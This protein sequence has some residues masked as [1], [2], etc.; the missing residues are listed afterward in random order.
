[1]PENPEASRFLSERLSAV[2]FA[3]SHGW[4]LTPLHGKKA[5]LDNW[6]TLGRP[7]PDLMRQWARAGN[8]GVR[9]GAVSGIFVI[10]EDPRNGG[11][12]SSLDLPDTLMSETGGAPAEDGRL[13]RHFYFRYPDGV[14]LGNS[15]GKLRP[16]IDTKGEGGQ[17]VLPGSIHPETG[18]P[19]RWLNNLN[20]AELPAHLIA[21]LTARPRAVSTLKETAAYAQAALEAEI[22]AVLNAPAH[23][24]N[25]VL[26][27]AAFNLGQLVGGGQIEENAVVEALLAAAVPRRSESEARSTIRSGLEAGRREPRERAHGHL[28][29]QQD[30]AHH[31]RKSGH[32]RYLRADAGNAELFAR[33]HGAELRYDHRRGLWRV[34]AGHSWR[35]DD[36]GKAWRLAKLT[37]RELFDIAGKL[38][39]ADE[40]EAEAKWAL[41]SMNR[42]RLSSMLRLAQNEPPLS[43]A[44]NEWDKDPW[45]LGVRNGVV[46]LRSGQLRPGRRVDRITKSIDIVYQPDAEAPRWNRLVDEVLGHDQSLVAFVHRAA[47]YSATGSTREQCLFLCHGD[48]SNGKST[49]LRTMLN[50]LGPYGCNAPFSTLEMN[51]RTSIP[52]DVARLEG[53]RLVTASET[54]VASRLNEARVKALTGDDPMSACYKYGHWFTFR[55]VLKLWLAV[56]HK[57]RVADTTRAFWRRVRLIPFCQHFDPNADPDLEATLAK[58]AP[59]ILRW[60]LIGAR[61]WLERGLDPP[62][63]ITEATETYRTESDVLAD[64]LAQCTE[65]DEAETVRAGPAYLAYGQWADQQGLGKYERLGSR[66]F[67]EEMTSRYRKR[68]DKAGWHYLGLA[69]T[70]EGRELLDLAETRAEKRAAQE[71][72]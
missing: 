7:T 23:C 19:Y 57:P 36:D 53:R 25:D 29:P 49:L 17:V 66:R 39:D 16:G 61:F 22:T 48:G 69:L 58:E 63:T 47:G 42:E 50:T 4:A 1:M 68:H 37:A 43:D 2:E 6:T 31:T 24:G 11:D 8:V 65:P 67:G 26:N 51:A 62:K 32:A 10:D 3:I 59:G 40:R 13:G 70:P 64:F 5:F 71:S 27:T 44:G 18:R 14:R 34:W 21:K 55:P 30:S 72:R 46:D 38:Q 45:L 33:M 15:S 12:V 9:T 28:S 60:I 35:E 52:E 54:S 20:P 41:K 56:N